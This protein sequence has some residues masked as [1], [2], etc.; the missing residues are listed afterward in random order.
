MSDSSTFTAVMAAQ[1][2]ARARFNALP[3]SLEGNDLAAFER[4]EEQMLEA[5][6]AADRAAPTSWAEFTRLLEHM[7][8]GGTDHVDG[9][10]VARLVNHAR[11]LLTVEG[12]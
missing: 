6:R 9:D 1:D 8:A 5:S 12:R 7:S 10:N 11:R 3:P 2:A 4:E